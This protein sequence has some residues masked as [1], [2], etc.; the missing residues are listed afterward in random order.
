MT[1]ALTRAIR[2]ATGTV[3][4]FTPTLAQNLLEW[5]H[6]ARPD[7]AEALAAVHAAELRLDHLEDSACRIGVAIGAGAPT[8][9]QGG[10]AGIELRRVEHDYALSITW[11]DTADAAPR[12]I[13]LTGVALMLGGRGEVFF[14]Q[15]RGSDNRMWLK[16][17]YDASQPAAE[18]QLFTA[19]FGERLSGA[20]R[21]LLPGQLSVG[22]LRGASAAVEI[23]EPS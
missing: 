20:M 14:A 21:A 7:A 2:F 13:E 22:T 5:L 10:R 4:R 16:L 8:R 19:A 3:L 6:S 12:S 23:T 18:V 17:I 11:T 9:W 15:R 1:V